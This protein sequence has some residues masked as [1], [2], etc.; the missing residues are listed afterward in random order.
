[1]NDEIK[2]MAIDMYKKG[3]KVKRIMEELNINP[4]NLYKIIREAGIVFRTDRRT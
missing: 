3:E 1:M 4:S 2:K